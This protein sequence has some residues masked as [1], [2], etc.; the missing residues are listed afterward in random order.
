[1][2]RPLRDKPRTAFSLVE[3]LVA[4]VFISI[5]F[6]GYVALHG[7]LLHSGQQLE[8]R[9]VIRSST[10]FFEG[11]E[12]TRSLLGYAKSIDGTEYPHDLVLRNLVTV[13]TDSKNRNMSWLEHYPED[14]HH[15]INDS[16]P[17]KLKVYQNPFRNK[18]RER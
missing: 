9:E 14:F 7:R 18:W 8:K 17:M 5:G 12:V 2:N 15:G 1:M 3:I 13:S 11:L 10:D 16:I 6:F 4:I